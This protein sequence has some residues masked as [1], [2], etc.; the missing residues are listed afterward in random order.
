MAENTE[1]KEKSSLCSGWK[2]VKDTDL[3]CRDCPDRYVCAEVCDG[4]EGGSIDGH[5]E[6]RI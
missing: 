2:C 3:C 1:R 5:C 6:F 4:P